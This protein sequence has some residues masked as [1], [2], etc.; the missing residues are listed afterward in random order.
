MNEPQTM[1]D[2]AILGVEYTR[3]IDQML[4][5]LWCEFKALEP[6]YA[7]PFEEGFGSTKLAALAIASRLGDQASLLEQLAR[8]D[9]S[10]EE[11]DDILQLGLRFVA[12]VKTGFLESERGEAS[13]YP[14]GPPETLSQ[15]A[16]RAWINYEFALVDIFKQLKETDT[17][18]AT[19][20]LDLWSDKREAAEF[21]ATPA[22]G[23]GGKSPLQAVEEGERQSLLALI[24]RLK[25]GSVP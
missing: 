14:F 21:V 4:T 22:Q 7:A 2:L 25:H 5:D 9:L 24:D 13:E 11:I 8:K 18:V 12:Q 1:E 6:D 16:H 10:R 23:L 20:V 15:A 17:E 3:Q 19:A